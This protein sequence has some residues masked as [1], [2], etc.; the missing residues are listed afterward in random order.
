[1]LTGFEY[2]IFVNLKV[3]VKSKSRNLKLMLSS[4]IRGRVKI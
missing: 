1:M 4:K 3:I 2:N